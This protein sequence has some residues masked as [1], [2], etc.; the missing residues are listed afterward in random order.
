MDNKLR[1]A[2]E[3]I[4]AGDALKER[5]FKAVSSRMHS[6]A[7]PRRTGFRPLAAA[8]ACVLL[9]VLGGYFSYTTPVAAISID[10]NPSVELRL[11]IYDRVIDA[12]GYND[13]GEELLSGLSVANMYYTDAI[14]CIL[15]DESIADALSGGGRLEVTVACGSQDRAGRLQ[16]CIAEQ[17]GVA[18]EC[19]YCLEGGEE[20]EAAHSAG[21]SLGKYRAYLEL[22]QLDPNISIEDIS[23]LSMHEIRD[24]IDALSGE[25]GSESDGNG[26]S[27]G[28][29]NGC[30][31][32]G[33]DGPG[34]GHGGHGHGRG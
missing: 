24:M 27:Q 3:D 31:I 13:D 5:T 22:K 17:T 16:S 10:V 33:G 21:I 28:N 8:A 2:F 7:K 12:A 34:T 25:A 1:T 18:T 29:G 26:G 20:L 23:G 30:G 19:I 15:S 9:L 4:H 6:A 11:N 14:N 32:S